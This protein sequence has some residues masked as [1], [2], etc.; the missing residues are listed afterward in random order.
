MSELILYSILVIPTIIVI[1]LLA[2]WI[3]EDF[4]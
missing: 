2:D 3:R 1:V 4:D